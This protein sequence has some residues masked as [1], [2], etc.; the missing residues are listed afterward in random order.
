M[1]DR[2]I[3]MLTEKRSQQKGAYSM[4]DYTAKTILALQKN[5]ME[6]FFLETKEETVPLLRTLIHEGASVSLGSS[7]TLKQCGVFDE[8]HTDRYRL[9]DRYTW[10]N[11]EEEMELMRQGLLADVQL[12]STNAITEDGLLYNVD[13]R[14]SR[15]AGLL[16]GPKQVI[17]IAGVN[18]IV[19]SLGDAILRVKTIAA[20]QNSKR[21]GY[22]NYCAYTGK[23]LSA[24]GKNDLCIGE[25][26]RCTNRICCNYVVSGWQHFPGRIKIVLVNEDLGY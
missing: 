20:P 19:P 25:G 3:R 13:C 23:C 16:F 17:V 21:L 4:E 9:I 14:S 18:K 10:N 6:V 2:Y 11:K 26:C 24:N 15:V 12:M 8:V 1:K 22:E 5:N 7:V